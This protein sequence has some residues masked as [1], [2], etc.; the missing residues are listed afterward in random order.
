MV[1]APRGRYLRQQKLPDK[2]LDRIIRCFAY[3]LSVSEALA[4]SDGDL[5]LEGISVNTIYE[6]YSLI[7]RRLIDVGYFPNAAAVSEDMLAWDEYPIA[8]QHVRP[9]EIVKIATWL[10]GKRRGLVADRKNEHLSELLFR[11]MHPDKT[12][13][14]LYTEIRMILKAS[15]RLNRP[16]NLAKSHALH[17]EIVY[18]DHIDKLRRHRPPACGQDSHTT[19]IDLYLKALKTHTTRK[20]RRPFT[21]TKQ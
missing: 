11:C 19:I 13:Q 17:T 14:R 4:T 18:R 12:G 15:G 1:E 2:M 6:V 21:S 9:G 8:P 7:R 16:P 5:R 3:G 20:R 10:L